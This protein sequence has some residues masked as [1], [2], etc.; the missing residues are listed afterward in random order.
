MAW[1]TSSAK[2][3]HFSGT[4]TASTAEAVAGP[5]PFRTTKK[6]WMVVLLSYLFTYKCKVNKKEIKGGYLGKY[7]VKINQERACTLEIGKLEI[8]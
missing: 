2:K 7:P 1:A 6:E 3:Q 8:C 5:T 4:H